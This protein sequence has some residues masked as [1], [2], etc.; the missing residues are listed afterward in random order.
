MSDYKTEVVRTEQ[1]KIDIENDI[2]NIFNEL[3]K[4]DNIDKDNVLSKIA[5]S[6]KNIK[7]NRL[8]FAEGGLLAVNIVEPREGSY[9]KEEYCVNIPLE[10]APKYVCLKVTVIK[11][12]NVSVTI[13]MNFMTN[14]IDRISIYGERSHDPHVKTLSGSLTKTSNGYIIGRYESGGG[15]SI[16]GMKVDSWIAFG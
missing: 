5:P 3:A 10:F 7:S 15:G 8:K 2:I 9:S 6:I 12:N 4:D 16:Y 14:I 11:S 1:L 13:L